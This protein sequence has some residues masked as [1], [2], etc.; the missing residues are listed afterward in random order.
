[1]R[2]TRM[3]TGSAPAAVTSATA[4]HIDRGVGGRQRE[5]CTGVPAFPHRLDCCVP[6]PAVLVFA[7]SPP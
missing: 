1:M 3:L 7:C 2:S 5:P 4:P 6:V